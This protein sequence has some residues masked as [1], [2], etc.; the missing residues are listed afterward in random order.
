MTKRIWISLFVVLL[1]VQFSMAYDAEQC[2]EAR[3]AAE[4]ILD[5]AADT[6]LYVD[7]LVLIMIW[8]EQGYVEVNKDHLTPGE[9]TSVAESAAYGATNKAEGEYY[10]GTGEWY[11]SSAHS[12]YVDGLYY[13]AGANW[14]DGYY[15][16]TEAAYSWQMAIYEYTDA[17]CSFQMAAEGYGTAYQTVVDALNSTTCL[18]CQQ[19]DASCTCQ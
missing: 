6:E 17:T 11:S 9:A 4:A 19:P 18:V 1:F 5:E 2:G 12:S 8:Q 14:D 15:S 16:F 3:T 7:S 13:Q 10:E